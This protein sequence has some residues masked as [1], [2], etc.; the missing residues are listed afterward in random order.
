MLKSLKLKQ[1]SNQQ[2]YFKHQAI[3]NDKT[4]LKVNNINGYNKFHAYFKHHLVK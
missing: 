4:K 1:Q 3:Y 2:F